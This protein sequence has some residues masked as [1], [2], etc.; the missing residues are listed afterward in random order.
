MKK[1]I[2]YGNPPKEFQFESGKSGNPS[3]RPKKLPSMRQALEAELEKRVR[4]EED[5]ITVMAPKQVALVKN[6][7]DAAV[8][9]NLRA[10]SAILSLLERDQRDDD[11][12]AP[13]GSD[14]G[15]VEEYIEREVQLRLKARDSG[16]DSK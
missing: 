2:G 5:G 16:E 7:V 3:G 10:A 4:I 15:L 12:H 1:R 9:G 14:E 13:D 6:L 11:Q 8:G